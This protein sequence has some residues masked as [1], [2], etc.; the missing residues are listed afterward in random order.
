MVPDVRRAEHLAAVAAQLGLAAA[1]LAAPGATE[2]LGLRYYGV[3]VLAAPGAVRLLTGRRPT[4][5]QRLLVAAVVSLHPIGGMYGV[6]RGVWWYDHVAHTAA[7]L[8]LAGAA[9]AALAGRTR[10]RPASGRAAVVAL[11]AVLVVGAAWEVYE[12]VVPW[13]TV[14]GAPDVVAD[15][16]CDAVGWALALPVRAHLVGMLDGLGPDGRPTDAG[17]PA[18]DAAGAAD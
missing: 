9:F 8:V 12:S 1:V 2:G 13:L 18:S 6:Y 4:P 14:Y 16:T 17:G 11:G 15:L 10:L 7:G 3:A 5:W